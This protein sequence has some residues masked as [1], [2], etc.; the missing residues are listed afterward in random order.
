MRFNN[1]FLLYKQSKMFVQHFVKPLSYY[2]SKSSYLNKCVLGTTKSFST[3]APRYSSIYQDEY[4]F[5]DEIDSECDYSAKIRESYVRDLLY[6]NSKDL[7]LN[8]IYCCVSIQELFNVLENNIHYYNSE[9]ITQ[10]VLVLF[11]LRTI[12][13]DINIA[14]GKHPN[15]LST[16]FSQKL[17]ENSTFQKLLNITEQKI[18][19]FDDDALSYSLLY[20]NKLGLNIE[21]TAVQLLCHTLK[22]KLIKNFCLSRTARFLETV[23]NEATLRPYFISQELVPLVL[24]EIDSC[25]SPETLNNLTMCLNKLH[26]IVTEES[27]DKYKEKV[28]SFI[29]NGV[30]TSSNYKTIL[31]IIA[32]LNYPKWREKNSVLISKC[33]LLM[34]HNLNELN[35]NEIILMYEIFFKIQEPG[36]ILSNLQRCSSKHFH[37]LDDTVT[38][39]KIELFSTILYFASPHLRGRFQKTLTKYVKECSNYENLILLQKLLSYV[40]I[41]DTKLCKLYW[42]KVLK[43]LKSD[44]KSIDI[45][46]LCHNYMNFSISNND[47]RHYEFEKEI[48]KHLDS[49]RKEVLYDYFPSELVN[50]L[51]F[52]LLYGDDKA[53]LEYLVNKLEVNWEQLKH[54]DCL[55]LALTLKTFNQMDKKYIKLQYAQRI[56]KVLDKLISKI[57]TKS[58]N[59]V[60]KNN[61]L[62]K[63]C[64]FKNSTDT[65]LVNTL[66]KNYKHFDH[67]TSK[68]IENIY[69]AFLATNTLIPEVVDNMTKYII[70]YKNHILGFNVGKVLYLCYC[71]GYYPK[72]SEDFFEHA[73][74]TII[75]DQER[76]TGLTLMY[77]ALALCFFNKLPNSI[78]QS[79]FNVEFMDKLDKELQNCYSKV[80]I[81]TSLSLDLELNSVNFLGYI[82]P[83]GAQ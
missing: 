15:E 28:E 64:V 22:R 47:Y 55:R 6:K 7:L 5:D 34:K 79:I 45:I 31:Q 73:I 18:N 71:F 33:I 68:N 27:F 20:L 53:L 32:F 49:L 82:S 72:N 38:V 2:H 12:Y 26:K 61:V 4:D 39:E 83:Q 44:S 62:L 41:T 17:Q 16:E 10:T 24:N 57:M 25:S 76:M 52:V 14:S 77:C 37:Q 3:N 29:E 67:I 11:D 74:N 36:T 65:L 69:H 75:R 58:D 59:D 9:H 8:R 50:I 42:D 60:W 1:L 19:C 51:N 70:T 66:L 63:A 48:L 78:I 30:I 23:F 46:K 54:V 43:C 13:C 35:V 40:K 80:N 56:D 21:V 81:I